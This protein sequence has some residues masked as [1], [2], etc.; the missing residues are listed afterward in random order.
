MEGED[1]ESDSDRAFNKKSKW[2]RFQIVFAG[3]FFNFILAY[4]LSVIYISA[5]GINDT[6]I[7][8]VMPGLP[9]EE[10]GIEAG[11]EI[12]SINGYRVHFYNEI[13][14]YTFLHSKEDSYTVV[15]KRDGEK[16]TTTLTP[17]YSKEAGRRL[18]GLTKTA[19]YRKLSPLG[20]LQYSAYE[21]KYQIYTTLSSLRLLFTGE[22]SVNE[23]SGPVGVVTVISDVYDQSVS[24]GIFYIFVNLLSIA[25]LLTANLGVMNLLPFPALDGGRIVLIIFEAIRG[26][27]MKPE[28]EN[29]INLVGFALLMLLMIVVMYND[30]LKLM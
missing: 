8:E 10:A 15:Y 2:E 22:V 7:T 30:I 12:I 19:D 25:I 24:S 9:A 5:I 27:K 26:K 11:D 3:P 17:V 4:V 13:S 23:M 20:V 14:I 1:E 18:I 28:I 6:T 21:I 16:H 29:G